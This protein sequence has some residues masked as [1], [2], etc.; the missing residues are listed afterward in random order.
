MSWSH[1]ARDMFETLQDTKKKQNG[2]LR[3]QL[4]CR[5]MHRW[6]SQSISTR[7]Q[8]K[9]KPIFVCRRRRI[10]CIDAFRIVILLQST[11]IMAR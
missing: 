5:R 4:Q 3:L 8:I 11:V 10:F 7:R 1:R 2:G 6:T 9:V